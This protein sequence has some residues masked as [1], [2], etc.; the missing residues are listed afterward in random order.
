MSPL[1]RS[2]KRPSERQQSTPN[3]DQAAGAEEDVSQFSPEANVQLRVHN[4]W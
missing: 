4:P 3:D 2:E 1:I